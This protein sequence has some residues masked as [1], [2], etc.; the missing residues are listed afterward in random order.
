MVKEIN[1]IRS[2][3]ARNWLF[4]IAAIV[5]LFMVP[6][7]FSDQRFLMVL[8]TFAAINVIVASGLDILFGYSGQISMGHAGFYAIGAYGSAVLSGTYGVSPWL[9]IF[10]ATIAA[11]II[12]FFFALPITK[13]VF[14]FLSLVTIAFGE[15]VF[16]LIVTFLDG[17]TGGP[18]GFSGIPRFTIFE[19][20]IRERSHF[21]I[22]VLVFMVILILLKWALMNSR[23]GRAFVA[24]RE[25][26]VAAAGMGINV[27]LYKAIAFAVSAFYTAMAGALLAH[28]MG[29]I[30]H[31]TFTRQTSVMFI[32]MVLFGGSGTIFGPILGAAI[33]SVLGEIIQAFGIYQMLIYGLIIVVVVIFAPQGLFGILLSI[34][35]VFI[36]I[37][38]KIMRRPSKERGD[39]NVDDSAS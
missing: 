37:F 6:I 16:Q 15:I 9:S 7:V 17:W 28:F 30:S 23:V 8:I 22:L 19:F 13:L 2:K 38:S 33:L 32:T 24:I 31:E 27:R 26:P 14:M 25:N 4:A 5:A 20:V 12:A 1:L 10:I 18:L 34:R 11:T 35:K 36:M 39:G 3:A 29:F 21:L